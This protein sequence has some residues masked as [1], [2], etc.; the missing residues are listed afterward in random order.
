MGGI[1]TWSLSFACVVQTRGVRGSLR[2]R[3]GLQVLAAC[4]VQRRLD[5]RVPLPRHNYDV[6]RRPGTEMGTGDAAVQ[7]ARQQKKAS[8]NKEGRVEKRAQGL[9]SA[10]LNIFGMP[11]CCN[12]IHKYWQVGWTAG[13][14]PGIGICLS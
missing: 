7:T 8:A 5:L 11:C 4:S 13:G 3:C 2:L 1:A 6:A 9:G 10:L 14:D 12:A